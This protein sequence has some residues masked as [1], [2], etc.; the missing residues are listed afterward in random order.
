MEGIGEMQGAF[1]LSLGTLHGILVSL[2]EV[3]LESLGIN[4]ATISV[5][6]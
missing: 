2:F 1:D 3:I 6:F 5:R 4:K